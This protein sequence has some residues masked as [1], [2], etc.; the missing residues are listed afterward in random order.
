M[1]IAS[2]QDQH[3]AGELCEGEETGSPLSPL[4]EAQSILVLS[5]EM[6]A[7]CIQARLALLMS[8]YQKSHTHMSTFTY[9]HSHVG[10]STVDFFI[11]IFTCPGYKG[12]HH[13]IKNYVH[14]RTK[15]VIFDFL[16]FF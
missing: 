6:Q 9:M 10:M 1:E 14:I 8:D 3:L 16:K 2:F 12:Q 13:M 4:S 11:N 5:L 7:C 15:M